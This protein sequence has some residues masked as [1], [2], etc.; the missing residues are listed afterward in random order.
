MKRK[1]IS[2]LASAIHWTRSDNEDEKSTP[3][4]FVLH[5][6]LPA[7][8]LFYYSDHLPVDAAVLDALK[9]LILAVKPL[10]ERR[11]GYTRL[12]MARPAILM[13]PPLKEFGIGLETIEQ[14][15]K[16]AKAQERSLQ[17]PMPI[18]NFPSYN[19]TNGV[20]RTHY[21]ST[22][23]F[24]YNKPPGAL[25]SPICSIVCSPRSVDHPPRREVRPG[26]S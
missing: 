25:K 19:L 10:T 2:R 12:L 20:T 23:I 18:S 9:S 3:S 14:V 5:L 22:V 7:Y 11:I 16:L 6:K 21:K 8:I 17:I 15:R 13:S 4:A 1:L 26:Y 24:I